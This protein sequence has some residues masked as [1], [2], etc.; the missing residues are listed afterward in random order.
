MLLTVLTVHADKGDA[1]LQG[2]AV[3]MIHVSLLSVAIKASEE[4]CATT[5][6]SVPALLLAHSSSRHLQQLLQ[7]RL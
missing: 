6:A 3:H 2:A 7:P 5:P 1:A 4:R